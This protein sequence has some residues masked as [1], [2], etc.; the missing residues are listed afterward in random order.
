YTGGK[1]LGVGFGGYWSIVSTASFGPSLAAVS[2]PDVAASPDRSAL[3]NV[4]LVGYPSDAPD[5]AHRN[6]DYTSYYDDG[7]YPTT[8]GKWNPSGGTGYWTW[9][10]TIYGAGSW[11]DLPD[12]QGVLFIAKLGHGNVYYKDSDRHAYPG[13]SFTWYV[14]DPKDLAAV[15]TGAKKQWE[16]QP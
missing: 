8:P 12:R 11:I 4:P 6:P 16:I 7:T 15:A 9:S 13:C 5:R 2:D 14:Y 1:S 3:A 10:D